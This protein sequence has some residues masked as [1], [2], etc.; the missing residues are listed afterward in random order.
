M[1]PHPSVPASVGPRDTSPETASTGRGR[2]R[3]GAPASRLPLIRAVLALVACVAICPFLFEL[4][5]L[6]LAIEDYLSAAIAAC[7]FVGV[8]VGAVLA[9]D[10]G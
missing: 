3:D 7:V 2:A 6:S 9:V 4:V 1:S 10:R 5:H 8:V